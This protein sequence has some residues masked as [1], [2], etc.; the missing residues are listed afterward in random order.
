MLWGRGE[1]AGGGAWVGLSAG[2]GFAVAAGGFGVGAA[3]GEEAVGGGGG[4]A[5]IV[6]GAVWGVF[7]G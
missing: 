7:G 1:L 6:W 4:G 2:G 5:D 3:D